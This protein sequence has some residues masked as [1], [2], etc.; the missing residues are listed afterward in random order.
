MSC[1]ACSSKVEKAVSSLSGVTS[2]SVNLL[3]NSMNVEGTAESSEIIAAVE[4]AGYSANLKGAS[5]SMEKAKEKDEFSVMKRRFIVSLF[6]L[7]ILMYFSMGNMLGLPLPSY[8]SDNPLSLGL[9][10]LYLSAIILV[11]NQK[12]FINGIK[13]VIH[14]APN[15]DTLVALG[16]SASF[17]YSTYALFAMS[18]L[19]S[20]GDTMGAYHYI[21]EFYFESAA[22][23][24]TLI[25]L[26][27]MLEARSK[28]KT[29]DAI[30]KLIDL[31]PKRAVV[32]RNGAET[33]IPADEI[34]KGDIFIVKAGDS[35][36]ADGIVI[37]GMSAVDESALTGESL[38]VDKI[39]GDR[40]S[41]ATINTSGYLK[42]EAV[43][44]G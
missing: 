11:I 15:M 26:G 17:I 2:C 32:I 36:P 33:E 16:M 7:I 44:V 30:K 43:G 41:A 14:K 10:E 9:I 6:F 24:P 27:K 29:T 34:I 19:I 22:M 21:H 38:P 1:A 28:G 40:V 25:T 42:C 20:K 39:V 37:E 12:F 3:T 4:K 23:I 35:I 8:F 13:G 18:D 5:K 31:T